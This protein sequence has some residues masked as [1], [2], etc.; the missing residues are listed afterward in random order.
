MTPCG[1][2]RTRRE[3]KGGER[4]NL[5]AALEIMSR[6]DPKAAHAA[7][8]APAPTA[9]WERTGM[10]GP[11]DFAGA[12]DLR[13]DT[14]S[15]IQPGDWP[16]PVD[17]ERICF[18]DT[19]TTGLAGGA[20]TVVFEIGLGRLTA[21]GYAVTQLVM[22]DYPE[23]RLLLRRTAEIIA[24]SDI[25]CTFNGRTFDLPLLQSRFPMNRMNPSVLDRPHLDLITA[26]R[27]VYRL[28][29]G[30]CRLQDL[31]REALGIRRSGDLPGSEA[32]KRFFEYL[33]TGRFSLL[34]DVLRHNMQD[35][36]SLCLLL[37]HLAKVY[38]EPERLSHG[39][40]LYGMGAG[41]H[42]DR[43]E[44]EA[45]R[46]WRLV[47]AGRMRPASRLQLARSCRSAG[48][49]AEA[50]RLWREMIDRREGGVQ[51][52]IELAKHCEHA[53]RDIPA[54]LRY[55]RQALI[56]LAEPA[57]GTNRSVQETKNALQYRYA[58][59]TRKLR[60]QA[61]RQAAEDRRENDRP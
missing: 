44:P 42:R 9:C 22:R 14:L 37:I 20:G 28:R 24:Q 6:N 19:E 26:A 15:L 1:R 46:C 55:T 51:P 36:A 8:A 11:G 58:R 21:E 25:I 56:L 53:E 27:R 49:R 3:R 34:E 4:V 32:P 54:A 23:E 12:R 7:P 30:S 29:L 38:D 60:E 59:L 39:E 10:F 41:L 13:A 33:R 5:K 2:H 18:L 50:A 35:I 45:R 47:R 31:E 61:E 48:D 40:D 57:L 16:D 52:Y 43:R 17:P